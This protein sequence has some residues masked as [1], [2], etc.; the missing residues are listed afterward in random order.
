M[1]K[2]AAFLIFYFIFLICD[3]RSK[4]FNKYLL[5]AYFL[6]GVIINIIEFKTHTP[7]YFIS[8][9]YSIAFGIGLMI[10]SELTNEMIGLGDAIYFLINSFYISFIDNVLLFVIGFVIALVT[11]FVMYQFIK[12]ASKIGRLPFLLFLAAPIIVKII[13]LLVEI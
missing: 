9:A 4:S 5:L 11:G 8:M 1:I 10:I 6:V 7:D 13:M 3:L 12:P 2:I